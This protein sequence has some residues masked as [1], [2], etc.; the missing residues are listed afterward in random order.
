MIPASA[1]SM[2]EAIRLTVEL[3]NEQSRHSKTV[4]RL[5]CAEQV[6]DDMTA[7]IQDLTGE[8]YGEHSNEND[9]WE[10]ALNDVQAMA[11]NYHKAKRENAVLIGALKDAE[12]LLRQCSI[13]W[14]EA[15]CMVDSMKRSSDSAREV[16]AKCE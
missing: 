12:W 14:K 7:A 6:L 5:E 1:D 16:L 8:Y 9:P 13:N 2:Q 15:G 11:D 3:L 10:N 4:S